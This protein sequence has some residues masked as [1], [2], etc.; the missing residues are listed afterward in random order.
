[1]LNTYNKQLQHLT[2]RL[3]IIKELVSCTNAYSEEQI[4]ILTAEGYRLIAEITKVNNEIFVE[5]QVLDYIGM[6]Q[7][8]Q[9][10]AETLH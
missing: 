4:E 8:L 1:M 7:K 5:S 3:D 10:S 6:A 2:A 9:E